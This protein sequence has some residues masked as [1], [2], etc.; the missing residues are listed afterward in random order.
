M[1]PVYPLIAFAAASSLATARV[2][3]TRTAHAAAV[4]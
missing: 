1:S 4:R 2:M 3:L